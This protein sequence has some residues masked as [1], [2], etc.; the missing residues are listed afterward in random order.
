MGQTTQHRKSKL[1]LRPVG[2]TDPRTAVLIDPSGATLCSLSLTP[3]NPICSKQAVAEGHTVAFQNV[4]SF[5]NLAADVFSPALVYFFC[6]ISMVTMALVWLS[7][8]G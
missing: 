2:S 4:T 5:S 3:L 1:G 6:C 7:C 8:A